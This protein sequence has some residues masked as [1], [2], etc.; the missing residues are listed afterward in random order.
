MKKY[1][2]SAFAFAVAF[3]ASAFNLMGNQTPSLKAHAFNGQIEKKAMPFK[4]PAQRISSL[5][6]IPGTYIAY[7]GDYFNDN[8]SVYNDITIEQGATET[9]LVIKGLWG[10]FAK[11]LNATIDVENGTISIPRQPFYEYE[12]DTPADFV[13]VMDT[14]AAVTATVYADGIVFE[15]YWGAMLTEGTNAGYYYT[16]G[17]NTIFLVPNAK[18]TWTQSST[19]K[20][21]NLYVEQQADTVIVGNFGGWG[22]DINVILAEGRT[23]N[24]PNQFI[25]DAGTTYGVFY[26]YGYDA[27]GNLVEDIPGTGTETTLTSDC[28]WTGRAET[29]Y[30]YGVRTPFTITRLDDDVFVWPG[31]EQPEPAMYVIGSF[32]NWDQDNMLAMAKDANG[33]WVVTQEMAENAEFKFR[34][35]NGDWFGGV[36]DGGNFIVTKE[37]VEQG[38]ELELSN[39]GMNFQIPVAGTWTFTIDPETMKVVIAGEWV[40]APVEPDMVYILGEVNGNSWAPNVGVEMATE[41]NINFTAEIACEGRNDGYNYFSFTKK[42]ADDADAWDAIAP[43]RFGAVSEGDFE[44]TD[45][46]LGAEISLENSGDALKI[47]AGEYTLALNLETMKLVITKKAEALKHGDVT[48]DGN[49]DVEDVSAIINIILEKVS[50]DAYPGNADLNN[51][52]NIDIDDVSELVNIILAQ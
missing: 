20:E 19:A 34:N 22:V 5:A 35:E 52:G 31:E 3:A 12:G 16:I 23:F 4:A 32:N 41:D 44:V 17:V 2:L 43:Y 6:D 33:K 18:M 21:V 29:G 26:T 39:P 49:I 10:S 1:L 7:Y 48:G 9:D 15:D 47:A 40:D 51:S 14:T 11:D 8:A 50:A 24:V 38:T 42:L 28:N 30:Y 13:N 25:E 27:D 36:T 37:Q 46:L 45:E